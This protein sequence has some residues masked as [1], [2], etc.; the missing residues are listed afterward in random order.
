LNTSE[1]QE[2]IEQEIEILEADQS[3]RISI[4]ERKLG[5]DNSHLTREERLVILEKMFGMN[6]PSLR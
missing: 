5:L 2:L 1:L 6:D 4:L 3:T